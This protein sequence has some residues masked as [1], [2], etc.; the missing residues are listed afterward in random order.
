MAKID[1]IDAD[2]SPV[3]LLLLIQ[4]LKN[5]TTASMQDTYSGLFCQRER[6]KIRKMWQNATL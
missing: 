5:R 4:N 6:V 2:T 3:L 1:K